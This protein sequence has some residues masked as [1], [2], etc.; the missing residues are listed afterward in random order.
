V[1][2]K[3]IPRNKYVE[4][5]EEKPDTPEKAKWPEFK[6]C[7][8]T[9]E[10]IVSDGIDK[11]ELRKVCTEPTCP[12]HHPKKQTQKA[13][14]SFKAEQEKRRREEALVNATGIRVLQSIVSAVPVRLMKRDLVFIA[15]QLLPLMDEK[16]IELAAR[17]RSIK[18]KDG[19][20]VAK[21]LT[22]YI[23]KADE[24]TIAKLI[25]EVVILLSARSQSDGGT[26]LRAAAQVYGVDTDAVALKV[27]QEFTAK[28]KAKRAT[29]E[30]SKPAAKAKRAA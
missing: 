1:G 30:E 11:G 6:T 22:A 23:R 18:A 16:R 21:L 19:E 2:E 26:V 29:K 7:K 3:T 17:N 13:D 4:I 15:E 14:A 8:H 5:R 28:E 20:S 27:K 12:V 9:T 24:S 25:I 10:A